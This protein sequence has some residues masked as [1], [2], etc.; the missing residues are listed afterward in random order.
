MRVHTSNKVIQALSWVF[1][2][3]ALALAVF[4]TMTG[5]GGELCALFT[6]VAL[7]LQYSYGRRLKRESGMAVETSPWRR[8]FSAPSSHR[9]RRY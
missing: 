2:V 8:N 7:V 9:R 4:V 6:T 5:A 1:T 3:A